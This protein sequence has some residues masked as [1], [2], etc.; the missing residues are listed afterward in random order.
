MFVNQNSFLIMALSI[1]AGMAY[2]ANQGAWHFGRVVALFVVAGILAVTGWW[3][4][5]QASTEAIP[6]VLAG[7]KIVLVEYYSDY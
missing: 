5:R 6:T 1:L 2:W 7:G 4:H 3:A